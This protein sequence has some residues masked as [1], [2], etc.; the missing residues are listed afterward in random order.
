M[1]ETPRILI[2]DADTLHRRTLARL[3]RAKGYATA[4]AIS[5]E[6]ALATIHDDPPNLVL[7]NVRIPRMGGLQVCRRIK[8]DPA[9]H[10]TPVV[11]LTGSQ[12]AD[13]RMAGVHAG[14]DDFLAQPVDAGELYAR[15]ASLL[16][17]KHFADE[18]DSAHA[19]LV[20]LALTIER[21]DPYTNGRGQRV[22]SYATAIGRQLRLPPADLA[23]LHRGGFLHDI[24]NIAAP[25]AV[26]RKAGR[27][28][29]A[30]RQIVQQHTV[31]GDRLCEQLRSLQEVRPTI[32][33]HHERLDG[34]GYPDGLRGDEI[35]IVAQII[36]LAAA[37]DAM[38][39]ARPYKRARSNAG[40]IRE[41]E[42]EVWLGWRRPDLVAA[43]AMVCERTHKPARAGESARG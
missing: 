18:L 4:A 28:T 1:H 33:W 3:L 42:H 40:A 6:A 10:L 7:L 32:R 26:L 12:D 16:R 35:P 9:T 15:V 38:T 27:L 5:G 41:L 31:F 2:A 24:G 30:E 37:Y 21:R 11:L 29:H 22:A 14:A 13:Y 23:V 25:D 39:T 19:V 17:L 34:G 8:A 20:S 36:S 43:L